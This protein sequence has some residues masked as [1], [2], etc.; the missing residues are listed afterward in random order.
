MGIYTW[1]IRPLFRGLSF[2][3]DRQID[4]EDT[5]IVLL[6]NFYNDVNESRVGRICGAIPLE[7]SAFQFDIRKFMIIYT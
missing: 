6:L 1:S 2:Y 4:S 7:V 3:R 5:Y